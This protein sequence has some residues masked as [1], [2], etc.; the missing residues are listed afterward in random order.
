MKKV[1][2][3]FSIDKHHEFDELKKIAQ[4]LQCFIV[5]GDYK[6]SIII[7]QLQADELIK[8]DISTEENMPDFIELVEAFNEQGIQY[9]L[10]NSLDEGW[11]KCE[12][13]DLELERT[14]KW[15]S[16]LVGVNILWYLGMTFLQFFFIYDWYSEKYEW[17]MIAS[18]FTGILTAL[19]PILGSLVAYWSATELSDWKNYQ[20]LGAFFIYY[21]PLALFFLYL[22]W[23]LL[24]AFYADRWYRFRHPEFN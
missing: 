10:Y 23:L 21:I 8:L 6:I 9:E 2:I 22:A 3:K 17:G 7:K 18:I 13:D 1:A 15:L 5:E 12:L 24:K 14:P 20:A 19:V 11:Q 16:T 4:Q